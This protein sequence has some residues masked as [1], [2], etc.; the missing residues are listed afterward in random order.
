MKTYLQAYFDELKRLVLEKAQITQIVPADCYRLSLEIKSKTHRS[1]SETTIK[2]IFSFA[3]AMHQPSI[4][5]LNA[6]AEYCGFKSWE[7][8]YTYL[9]QDRRQTTLQHS[10]GDILLNATK[11]SLFNIQSNKY[12][13]GVPYHFTVDRESLQVFLERFHQSGATAGILSG[14]TGVGKTISI[15][16]W[17][18]SRIGK[19]HTSSSNDVYLFTNSLS[20]LQGVAFGYH[21]N[22]WLAHMLGFDT[23]NLLDRFMEAHRDTAPGMFY[24]I[25]DELHS[26]L[27][28]D[29]Q[30][31]SIITHFIEMVR[32][33]AQYKWFRIIL[34]LRTVTL[35]KYKNLFE[36]TI[37]NPQWFSI[38]SGERGK[39]SAN[40]GDFSNSEL[41]QLVRNLHGKTAS[42]QLPK[43]TSRRHLI[44]TP[45][46]FQYYYEL[47]GGKVSL[48]NVTPFDEYL[49]VIQYLKKKVF[50]GVNT[51]AK[52]ALVA[53]LALLL[54]QHDGRLQVSRKQAYAAIKQHKSAYNDLLCAGLL[55][56]IVGD[57]EIRQQTAVQFQ[58]NTIAA[59]FMALQ[60]YNSIPIADQLIRTLDESAMDDSIK[61]EQLKWLLLFN[62]EFGNLDLV[63][64]IATTP[65][66]KENQFETIAFIC[67]G[68]DRITKCS[69]QM[70]KNEIN[71]GLYNSPFVEY[72]IHFTCFE[73]EYEY[74]IAKLLPFQL[75]NTHEI[76]IRTKLAFIA[77]LKWEEEDLLCQ[78]DALSMK[79]PKNFPI[80]PY[81]ILSRI[82]TCLKEG[83]I[84]NDDIEE[85]L[86]ALSNRLVL[87][88]H[89]STNPL[90]DL[91]VYILVKVSN[92]TEI[93]HRYGEFVRRQLERINPANTFEKDVGSLIYALFLLESN[94][95]HQALAFAT[96]GNPRS[97]NNLLYR[98]LH[99][100]FHMQSR[101]C[102]LNYE[103]RRLGQIAIAICEDHGFKLLETYCRI[104]ML[105][106]VSKDEQIQHINNIKFQF[107]AFGY[108]LGINA[109]SKKYG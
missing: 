4:Y 84:A 83:V 34:V 33:F 51:L 75:S 38:L 62:I 8:F 108:N 87:S 63:N 101:I 18:E 105:D 36:D 94:D 39:K 48:D 78:L 17:V 15:S 14:P 59:Y 12:K 11:I 24:L 45:L 3:S 95:V 13:C 7:S 16:R 100:I 67:D 52:Q 68:L 102:P 53:E 57:S 92:N 2:R 74:A 89:V 9:D 93:A 73:T 29:R 55:Q 106:D 56:E 90:F 107:A 54:E 44:H 81:R 97:Q 98:L 76:L 71:K 10:W 26:D 66:T 50:N 22:R 28:S 77:L 42:V 104:L 61:T 80:N 65:F 91:L 60:L 49:I 99:A 96:N 79:H 70:V 47:N 88:N 5:T 69:S 30:F 82:Y 40:L 25:I 35:Y 103:Y 41:R 46:F 64:E 58:S 43:P 1:I 109:I 31:C 32:S 21:S 19:N 6:L 72:A 23:S 85:E 86:N 20:L 37:I 27:V